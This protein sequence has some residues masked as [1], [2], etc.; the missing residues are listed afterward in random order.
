MPYSDSLLQDPNDM[1][2]QY[3]L[4]IANYQHQQPMNNY[5]NPPMMNPY[6]NGYTGPNPYSQL[7]LESSS[8]PSIQVQIA[9]PQN[10]NPYG[11]VPY[12][13]Y[14]PQYQ[15]QPVQPYPQQMNTG[16]GYQG[17]PMNIP[18]YNPNPVLQ[19]MGQN[20]IGSGFATQPIGNYNPY[21]QQ[22]Q[23]GMRT[24]MSIAPMQVGGGMYY[25][26]TPQDQVV[27]VPG[28]MTM[29]VGSEYLFPV[30]IKEKCEELQDKMEEE[31]QKAYE[32]RQAANQGFFNA[33][34]GVN[35]YGLWW[36]TNS[37][38]DQ[39]IYNKY[40]EQINLMAEEA[41]MKREKLNRQL[42]A[43]TCNCLGIEMN[44]EQEDYLFNGYSYTIPGST[45]RQSKEQERLARMVEFNPAEAYWKAYAPEQA[46]YEQF[47][48]AKT[49]NEW[50]HD[51]GILLNLFKLEEQWHK[52]KNYSNRYDAATTYS[53][54]LTKYARRQQMT[55]KE[56]EIKARQEKVIEEI[57]NGI[58]DNLPNT[59]EEAVEFL[60]GTDTLR[61]MKEFEKFANSPPIPNN[62][63]QINPIGPPDAFG[64][65]V[66][67]S[68]EIENEFNNRM[69]SFKN[70]VIK[71][72]ISYAKE[73]MMKGEPNNYENDE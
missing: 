5:M 60:F 47:N 72:N 34:P 52:N 39:G 42:Y 6:V 56:A 38:F 43:C 58:Y 70:T 59:R 66:V 68:D 65:P 50:L 63:G 18:H 24:P 41:R 8:N 36:N 1:S 49:M 45:I 10:I 53:T 2:A 14:Y 54:F 69:N 21:Y 27:H 31:M 55:Q 17:A 7:T 29:L 16:F 71:P 28:L 37:Y 11:N 12:G 61:E 35:Y 25:N 9:A 23:Q 19:P 20:P 22:Q 3:A 33:N 73:L 48:T 13:A 51:C 64:T 32:A 4:N 40:V 15:Q 62:G 44:P 57:K 46:F 30:D 26:P 67:V